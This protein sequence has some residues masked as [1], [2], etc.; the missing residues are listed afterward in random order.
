[1]NLLLLEDDIDFANAL[2][3]ALEHGIEHTVDITIFDSYLYE[4]P[5]VYHF[6]YILMDL[7]VDLIDL[8]ENQFYKLC[9][10]DNSPDRFEFTNF[11]G[12]INLFGLDYFVHKIM[13][14]EKTKGVSRS[15][16]IFISGHAHM[17]KEKGI[18]EKHGISNMK[19]IDKSF[20]CNELEMMLK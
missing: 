2:C 20:F 7:N 6:D 9:S 18:L 16:F 11:N 8:S 5:G 19:L 14:H 3:K 12:K 17:I 15:K 10:P 1:M 4:T 13:L